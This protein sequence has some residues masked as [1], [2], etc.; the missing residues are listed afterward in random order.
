M[1]YRDRL[2]VFMT[3]FTVPFS[4]STIVPLTT[5]YTWRTLCYTGIGWCL[6]SWRCSVMPPVQ[7][8]PHWPRHRSDTLCNWQGVVFVFMT[9]FTVLFLVHDV[10]HYVIIKK[11][12]KKTRKKDVFC[13]KLICGL[14][15]VHSCVQLCPL[16]KTCPTDYVI[17][18]TYSTVFVTLFSYVPNTRRVPLTTSQ[19]WRTL[20]Y[21]DTPVP[22]TTW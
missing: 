1:I 11:Y 20:C 7:D 14:V 19:K 2:L 16:Y 12:I 18:Q 8:V 15:C 22:L 13:V 5:S 21:T 6:C 17:K 10:S 9:L 4:A 3:L